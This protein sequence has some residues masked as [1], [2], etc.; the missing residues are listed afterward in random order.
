MTPKGV[1]SPLEYCK[2]LFLQEKAFTMDLSKKTM[3]DFETFCKEQGYSEK[4]KAEKLELLQKLIQKFQY[5]PGEAIG[6]IAAQSISEPAT[7]M[8]CSPYEKVILKKDNK[9]GIVEIGKF[10][11]RIVENIGSSVND[12]DVCDISSTDIYVPGIT[13]EEKIEWKKV[14]ACSRHKAPEKMLKLTTFSGRQI[15]ATPSHSFVTRKNN[16]IITAAGSDLSIGDRVPVIKYLPE[17]CISEINVTE[18]VDVKS[19]HENSGLLYTRKNSKPI[20]KKIDLDFLFG[21]FIGAYLSEGNVEKSHVGISNIDE[22]FI[23]NVKSFAKIIGMDFV[24]RIYNGEYGPGRTIRINSSLLA[25]FIAAT[26]GKGSNN[27][28]VPQFAYSAKEEFVSGLL[29]GYFDGDGNVTVSRRMV[30]VSSNSKELLDGIALLL[31]RFGIFAHKVDAKTKLKTQHGLII[32]YKYAPIFLEKIGSDIERKRKRLEILSEI[33]I[34]YWT[35]KSQDFTDVIGGFGDLFY[36]T[37]KKLGYP[38][39]YTNSSTKRQKIGRTVLARHIQLFEKLSAEKNIDI[40]KEL[41]I[42]KRMYNSDVVWDQIIKIEQIKPEYVYVYDLTVEGTETFTTFDGIVTHNTMRSYTMAS[43]SDRLS[44]V[45]HGLPRLI[46]IFD[47]RKTFEKHMKIYL[48]PEYNT[49]EKAKEIANQVKSKTVG[50]L[51]VSDS[52]DLIN[53]R[54]ELELEKESYKDKA[55]EVMIGIKDTE[56]TAKGALIYVK[57]KKDDVKNLRKLKNKLLKL[58]VDGVKGIENVI[59]VKEKDDWLIQS[60]GTNLKK[61]LKVEGVDVART[62]TND[63]YQVYEV[64]GVEAARNIILQEAKETLDEQGLEVDIRHLMLLADMMTFDGV[65]NDIGR[66]GVSGKKASVLARANFEETKKHL[67]NASFFGETDNLQGIIENIIVG[68]IPPIGTGMVQLGIDMDKM[69]AM[70]KK[71]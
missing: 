32:P 34:K 39:R 62:T 29:K 23:S 51:V 56:V 25:N 8:S 63:I 2:D 10:T 43:Q 68:Q 59:V 6:V 36:S 35:K 27:K 41:A 22:K 47:A 64:L 19:L 18:H 3:E 69:R 11:D 71:K 66:Y 42:M 14:L 21:W 9:I 31:T 46:E 54:V 57:P 48:M 33:S 52:I 50:S 16:Q 40:S 61:V 12:W 37:S 49:K 26:C 7:Q 44:K 70:A 4:Q 65:V 45:T 13:Q 38:S 17:N 15:I 1:C 5:E 53:M 60:V 24:D 30:R 55:K 28:K 67:V 58:Q 20:P